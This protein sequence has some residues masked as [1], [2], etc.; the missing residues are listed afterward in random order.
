MNTAPNVCL[1]RWLLGV[2]LAFTLISVARAAN[3]LN[4]SFE[5]VDGT[6][7]PTNW[8][9]AY[10][11]GYESGSTVTHYTSGGTRCLRIN[12]TSS[13]LNGG[14]R[15]DPVA[16]IPGRKYMADIK[17]WIGT[18]TTATLY[19][20]YRDSA[21]TLIS[22]SG[23]SISAISPVDWQTITVVPEDPTTKAVM[24]APANA[25]TV[26]LLAYSPVTQNGIIY[27]DCAVLK[28][29][30][31][32]P[33][34][35][36]SFETLDG[37]GFPT[38]WTKAYP[39]GYESS[40]TTQAYVGSRSLKINDTSASLGGGVRSDPIPV[41]QGRQ[42]MANVKCFI[43]SGTKA[44]V[45]LEY[46]TAEGTQMLIY[47]TD[48]TGTGAWQD[49]T[50]IPEEHVS[51]LRTEAPYGAS[52]ATI[53]L[54]S[55]VAQLG[56]CYFDNARMLVDNID[57]ATSGVTI[58]NPGFENVD[59]GGF[60]LEWTKYGTSGFESGS[61]LTV[62][63]GSRSLKIADTSATA[64]AGVLS[65]KF[66]VIEGK[67]YTATVRANV[68]SGT[69]QLYVQYFDNE[70]DYDPKSYTPDE[71]LGADS[72]TISGS[73]W[74]TATLNFNPPFLAMYAAV[75]LY[76][77][78]GNTGTAY[79]DTVTIAAKAKIASNGNFEDWDLNG[80]PHSWSSYLPSASVVSSGSTTRFSDIARS[81][82]IVD[83]S[84]S[85][86]GGAQSNW[87][88]N[89]TAG[90]SYTATTKAY[91]ESGTGTLTLQY[92]NS[93]YAL[94]S[95][96]SP[97]TISTTGSWQTATVSG[98]AP[99]N[100]AYARILLSST[101]A[102][103]GTA[104]YDQVSFSNDVVAVTN[105]RQL[106][107][108]EYV[109]KT[110]SNITKTV[111][112]GTKTGVRLEPT[113][114]GGSTGTSW[115]GDY[116]AFY[117]NTVLYDSAE[118]S[119][120]K[121]KM[122]YYSPAVY[123][124]GLATS[125]D[126]YNWTRPLNLGLFNYGG[127]TNNN[128]LVI[129]TQDGPGAP[130]ITNWPS[131]AGAVVIDPNEP[132]PNKR[133]KNFGRCYRDNATY[134]W[135]YQIYTSSNGRQFANYTDTLKGFDVSTMTYDTINAQC[136]AMVKYY[137]STHRAHRIAT[138]S[139]GFT[140][141]VGVRNESLSDMVDL[142]GG[143]QAADCYGIGWD[144]YEGTY[145]GFDWMFHIRSGLGDAPG[146]QVGPVE[147][148]LVFS[149]DLAEAW[150]R[151]SRT[152]IIP[153]GS[154]GIVDK[155]IYTGSNPVLTVGNEVYVYYSSFNNEHN[156]PVTA[157]KIKMIKWRLDGF[158]SMDSGATEGTILTKQMTYT[159]GALKLN[160]NSSGAGNYVKAELI[161]SAGTVITGYSAA[162]SAVM[163]TDNTNLTVTWGGSST[164]PTAGTVV[165]VKLYCKN[166]KVYALQFQ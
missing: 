60:P 38:N 93:S 80:Y 136:V 84:G 69:F 18:G 65:K 149:R 9:K 17:C 128:I 63:A 95:S 94:L 138:S 159:G 22:S 25:A 118:P 119:A 112:P 120:N 90:Q 113:G 101:V 142:Q 153:L 14:V 102:N 33:V 20:E 5:T 64:N 73:G 44:T 103:T 143:F 24:A 151:V 4:S 1:R 164:L 41:I 106:F 52:Y 37:G 16:V 85:V 53:M 135:H 156:L 86:E 163:N 62:D 54:Y 166:A 48:V 43:A 58:A 79:F 32:V 7:F 56:T 117:G 34:A 31:E 158:V 123:Y 165:Q 137:D 130:V 15:S 100:T 55:P 27:F 72:V 59:G 160:L 57:F 162:N 46:W 2:E 50:V 116:T 155:V 87:I 145:I 66:S 89:V 70:C 47:G 74:Q 114:T 82:K 139:N 21:G 29:I 71:Y 127:N 45:Y 122:Y 140:W 154:D 105:R 111:N 99:A 49:V 6:G 13:S 26:T 126:G 104:Y 10:A 19:L 8:T 125:S 77:T 91:V 108:D 40:S 133:W 97:A 78:Q 11:N 124:T 88:T 129:N 12:D 109:V 30:S 147:P 67:S 92:F 61:T 98:T 161:N 152:P 36:S 96:P 35:N 42:Y 28:E 157:G 146:A 132:D 121:Y 144:P 39:N 148:H 150:Y 75:L 134:D 110:T 107:I 83:S 81:L 3:V 51:N 141:T 76:S 68:S 115:E 23:Q 131:L